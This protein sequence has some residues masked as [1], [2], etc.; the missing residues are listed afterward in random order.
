MK[1][2]AQALGLN[3]NNSILQQEKQND[4]QTG[5]K[6]KKVT[7]NRKEEKDKEKEALIHTII[8]LKN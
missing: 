4:H 1:S 8:N 7:N 2:H 5:K 3:L 6:I